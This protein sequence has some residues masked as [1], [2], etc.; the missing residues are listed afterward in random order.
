MKF[1]QFF[2]PNR[3]DLLERKFLLERGEQSIP[4]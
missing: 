1:S 2:K 4:R 3:S